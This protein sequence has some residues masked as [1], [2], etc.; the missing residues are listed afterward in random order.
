MCL[1][2]PVYFQ[3]SKD[4]PNVDDWED[5]KPTYCSQDEQSGRCTAGDYQSDCC[6][7]YANKCKTMKAFAVIGKMVYTV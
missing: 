3:V 2:A 5:S 7:A 6:K 1:S 4:P